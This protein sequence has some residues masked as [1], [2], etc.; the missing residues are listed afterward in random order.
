MKKILAIL[1]AAMMACSMAACGS[2]DTAPEETPDTPAVETPA[3]GEEASAPEQEMMQVGNDSVGYVSIPADWKDIS[4]ADLMQYVDPKQKYALTMNAT[5]AD[6]L[7]AAELA[8]GVMENMK[9]AG[10][11]DA[12]LNEGTCNGQEATI[13]TGKLGT[14]HVNCWFF[15]VDDMIYFPSMEGAEKDL[16]AMSAYVTSS[17]TT[18]AAAE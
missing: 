17:F 6:G 1:M 10:L 16:E 15:Q 13:L 3:E 11:T 18:T 2:S 12:A 4:Q 5:T 9:T 14:T 7:T 8:E